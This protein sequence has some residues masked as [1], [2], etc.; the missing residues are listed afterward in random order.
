MPQNPDIEPDLQALVARL[1]V[2]ECS[3]SQCFLCGASKDEMTDEHVV[4]KWAQKR[5]SLWNQSVTLLNGTSF[6]Y[7]QLTTR[8]CQQCNNR[9]LQ[10]LETSISEAVD[11]GR[12]AV[13]GLGNQALLLWL[14]KLYY[15]ILYKQ[16]F[17]LRDQSDPDAGMIV[18]PEFL[19]IYENVRFLLQQVRGVI[20]L[21]DFQTGSV[22]VFGMQPLSS[23]KLEWELKVNTDTCFVG[24]R[25]GQI[26]LL[27]VLDDGGAQ[28]LCEEKF[29]DIIDLPL[30]P[31]Q[32]DELC[33]T[34]SYQATL[35]TRT[36]KYITVSGSPHEVCQMP[37]CGWTNAPLFDSGNAYA[38]AQFL[39]LYTHIP[40]GNL[41]RP[42]NH[43]AT[44][45]RNPADGSPR[46]LDVCAL[47]NGDDI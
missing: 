8:C 6:A 11:H 3:K 25:V 31:I 18:T 41:Y 2:I 21:G 29:N 28:Q 37:L 14:S 22:F 38:Y 44:Y 47:P 35:A 5:Y 7:R 13:V 12:K 32:F 15:G 33:A 1:D 43:V 30:H 4:P 16:L 10:P 36:P 26:A 24:C 45:L 27:G 34:I 46:F 39:S 9:R 19:H 40:I 23:P 42:P 20:Q 17:L